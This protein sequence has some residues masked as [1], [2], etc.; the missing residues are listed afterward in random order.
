MVYSHGNTTRRAVAMLTLPLDS[1]TLTLASLIGLTLILP[2]TIAQAAAGEAVTPS[3]STHGSANRLQFA[4]R[5]PSRT[6]EDIGRVRRRQLVR[7]SVNSRRSHPATTSSFV[8]RPSLPAVTRVAPSIDRSP[9]SQQRS[10]T[11]PDWLFIGPVPDNAKAAEPEQHT[12]DLTFHAEQ[13]PS[14]L[15]REPPSGQRSSSRSLGWLYQGVEVFRMDEA[16]REVL[17]NGH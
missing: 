9:R 4:A 6:R 16:T 11:I 3:L 2:S 5:R 17:R 15:L 14:R 1:R 13:S 7:P 10:T 12:M 8:K